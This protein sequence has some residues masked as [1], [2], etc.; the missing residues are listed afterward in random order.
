MGWRS[1][2]RRAPDRGRQPT[3]VLA[4]FAH[5]GPSQH[6]LCLGS[7]SAFWEP[8]YYYRGVS[9]GNQQVTGS[10]V[11]KSRAEL[12]LGETIN[13]PDPDESGDERRGAVSSQGTGASEVG[14]KEFC[15]AVPPAVA[16]SQK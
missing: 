4:K 14:F 7:D 16:Q 10:F 3:Q 5:G 12:I 6:C 1:P 2:R 13:C 8:K 9:C 15:S 11:I